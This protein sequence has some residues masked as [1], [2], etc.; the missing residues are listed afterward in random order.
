MRKNSYP[1]LLSGAEAMDLFLDRKEYRSIVQLQFIKRNFLVKNNLQ[2][3]KGLI[4]EDELFSYQLLNLAERVVVVPFQFY[5]R[6]IRE[7]SIMTT[8]STAKNFLGLKESFVVMLNDY[9]HNTGSFSHDLCRKC[10]VRIF[11]GLV[12]CY[13]NMSR[14]EQKKIKAEL[15]NVFKEVKKENCFDD[16]YTKKLIRNQSIKPVINICKRL[17]KIIKK[18]IPQKTKEFYKDIGNNAKE[19]V[20]PKCQNMN[21]RIILMCT[22]QHGN[23]GD[24]AIAMACKDY[25]RTYFH[26]LE[27]VEVPMD[28]FR[29]NPTGN[30]K[31]IV[32]NDIVIICGGGWLGN[33]WMENE[34]TFRQIVKGLPNNKIIVFP[35]TVFFDDSKNGQDEFIF[36][37]NIYTQ[38]KNLYIYTRERISYELLINK[39]GM[40]TDRVFLAPDMVISLKVKNTT[41]ERNKILKLPTQKSLIDPDKI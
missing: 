22:P 1:P 11:G 26:E 24:H 4:H 39:I 15:Q 37:Q 16:S 8:Q 33:L 30:L 9:I 36:S 5:F 18:A 3:K 12:A 28:S 7:G 25:L 13:N 31:H 40:S 20:V 17:L 19:I 29:K 38:H 14:I 6:R 41:N 10:V 23:L 27:L 2:F 34:K 21:N 35:Q 32:S